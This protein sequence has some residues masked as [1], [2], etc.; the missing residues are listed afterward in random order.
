MKMSM[1]NDMFFW[2]HKTH[3][4]TRERQLIGSLT[5]YPFEVGQEGIFSRK[6]M[7]VSKSDF[8]W[9]WIVVE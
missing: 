1:Y 3:Q 9:R 2:D 8:E 4:K 7:D 6:T 5:G